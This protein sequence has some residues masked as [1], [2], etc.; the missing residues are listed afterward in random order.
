MTYFDTCDHGFSPVP[1]KPIFGLPD[2][3]RGT[4]ALIRHLARLINR[5]L[6]K[7]PEASDRRR[8]LDGL[9]RD[10]LEDLVLSL[11]D[12]RLIDRR[13]TNLDGIGEEALKSIALSRT[14][15]HGRERGV[16]FFR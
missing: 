7:R 8:F 11:A 4:G 5:V 15:R 1:P 9:D 2:G 16:Y 12:A 3:R 14:F 13:S 10:A 6:T